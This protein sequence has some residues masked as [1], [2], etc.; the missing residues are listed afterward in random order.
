MHKT[1]HTHAR[2]DT[3]MEAQVPPS[4]SPAISRAIHAQDQVHPI[5]PFV[6]QTLILQEAS[7]F[8]Q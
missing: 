3:T 4:A 5:V 8:A 7:V 1:P 2:V 6:D